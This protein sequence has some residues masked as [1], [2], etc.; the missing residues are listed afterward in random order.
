VIEP[1]RYPAHDQ[2]FPIAWQRQSATA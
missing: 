1:G 2:A